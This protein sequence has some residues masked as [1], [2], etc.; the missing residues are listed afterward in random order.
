M[1]DRG[2]MITHMQIRW[3]HTKV[4]YYKLYIEIIII[5]HIDN[6]PSSGY[7]KR[8]KKKWIRKYKKWGYQNLKLNSLT[9][10][11]TKNN[12]YKVPNTRTF[13][14]NQQWRISVPGWSF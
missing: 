7:F 6:T 11:F 10:L 13:V 9:N 8:K 3:F 5:S 1:C 12:P 4:Y 14:I 2:R